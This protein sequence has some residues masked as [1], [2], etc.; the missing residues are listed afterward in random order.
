MFEIIVEQTI[1]AAH[2]LVIRTASGALATD[3][4]NAPAQR[5]HGHNWRIRAALTARRL[6]RNGMVYDFG[7]AE[8]ALAAILA[9]FRHRDLAA[10]PPFAEIN[11][12]AEVLAQ[13]VTSEL[14]R[15]LRDPEGR[16]LRVAWV[17]VSETPTCRARYTP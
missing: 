6:D 10:L 12:T 2:R 3:E 7:L 1:S 5:I 11:P 17:E 16:G 4:P 8:D 14:S 15:V 13:H 9:P